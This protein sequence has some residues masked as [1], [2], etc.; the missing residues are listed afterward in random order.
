MNYLTNRTQQ[1]LVSYALSAPMYVI[2]GVSQGS[3]LG[4]VLFCLFI[5]DL[6]HVVS[7]LTFKMFMDDVKVYKSVMNEH[8]ISL[9]QEDVAALYWWWIVN[10]MFINKTKCIVVHCLHRLLQYYHYFV[11]GNSISSVEYV[12][13]LGVCFDL[14]LKIDKHVL[15]ILYYFSYNLARNKVNESFNAFFI[16]FPNTKACGLLFVLL[17]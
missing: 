3:C 8:E 17:K 1:V 12:Q 5:N 14:S 2:S 13:A 9:L 15:D 7:N 16:L 10:S 4:L 6:T 11:D